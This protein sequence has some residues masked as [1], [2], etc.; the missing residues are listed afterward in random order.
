MKMLRHQQGMSL[1]ELM[2]AMALSLVVVYFV[3]QILIGS[4]QTAS[5]A[6]TLTQSQETGRF[7]I[8]YL[9][10][11]AL[12]AG[13]DPEGEDLQPFANLCTADNPTAGTGMCTQ[14]TDNTVDG[15][16]TGDRLAIVRTAE[17]GNATSCWGSNM[18][19]A[20]NTQIAD[21]FWVEVNDDGLSSLMCRTY[22]F[23]TGVAMVD[24]QPLAAG[25]I[26]MHVLYG[27]SAADSAT[28]ERNV[29]TYVP[30]DDLTNNTGLDYSRDWERVY[31]VRVA[32]L[33]QAFDDTSGL[34]GTRN[35]ILFDAAP[36]Q[37]DDRFARQVFTTTV[38]RANF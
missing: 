2:I 1:I 11:S 36:Y 31:S 17:A 15:E 35:Y 20:T 33:T 14:D 5:L 28:G 24:S 32:L 6:D 9:N 4:N 12:R 22:N 34:S 21:V 13:Y 16:T 19:L 18:V 3:M 27:Q 10:R 29:T 23:G 30:A 25:V 38:A 8:S 26:A 37:Y 7:S